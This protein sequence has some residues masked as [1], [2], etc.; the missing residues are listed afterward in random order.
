MKNVSQI[1]L[2]KIMAEACAE[3][4]AY[5]AAQFQALVSNI[6]AKLKAR[7]KKKALLVHAH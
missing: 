4:D 6:K 2:D 1:D 7:L 5:L 3:R